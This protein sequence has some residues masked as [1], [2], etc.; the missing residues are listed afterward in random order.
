[1]ANHQS[2]KCTMIVNLANRQFHCNFLLNVMLP[3]VE[4]SNIR[5]SRVFYLNILTAF[6]SNRAASE[7]LSH[8]NLL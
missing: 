7:F 6:Q 2:T 4:L 3:T 5:I 1:M 8:K